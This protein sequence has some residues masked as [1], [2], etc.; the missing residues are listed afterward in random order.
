[1]Q[2]DFSTIE[3]EQS[4]TSVPEGTYICKITDV[5]VR[6]SRDGSERWSVRLDVDEGDWAGRL[7][8]WDSV[9]WSERG[10]HRVKA[11]L[12]AL[13]FDVGG[14]VD[15]QPNDLLG[16][17]ACVQLDTEHWE[18]PATGVRV[19]RRRVPY[20]GYRSL[21]DSGVALAA[22]QGRQAESSAH[23]TDGTNNGLAF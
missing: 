8:A 18:N 12:A 1:M 19:E 3:D 21:G 6:D 23:G 9:T 22:G 11:V 4:Y 15:V 14:V 7:A 17:R 13:G 20:Q 16:L 10:M 5:R 2:H